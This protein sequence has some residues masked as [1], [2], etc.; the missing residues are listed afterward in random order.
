VIAIITSYRVVVVFF[1][2]MVPAI[3]EPQ[4]CKVWKEAVQIGDL[5]SR[6][7]EASG[8][9]ASREFAGRL[10]HINDSG[11]VGTFYITGLDGKGTQ[12]ISVMGFDPKDTEALSLGPCPG[13]KLSSCLYLGDIGDNDRRRNSIEIAVIDE[14]QN[15]PATVNARRFLKLRY[16]DGPHDAESMAVR[17]NGEI[18]LLT[19]EK[20]ARLFKGNPNLPEQTL[21][22]VTTLDAGSA[23]TDMAI[24]DDGMRLL[25]LTYADAFEY[26]MDFKELL[27]IQL[28]YLQQQESVA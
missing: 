17:P 14:M 20:P 26:S 10:Y 8:V 25:V 28:S 5:Q 13:G 21:T 4:M 2:F 7:R 22:A 16:P 24:S 11:D 23:P 9:A 27:N 18:L 6:V 15:F 12:S 19:K 3:A 1:A